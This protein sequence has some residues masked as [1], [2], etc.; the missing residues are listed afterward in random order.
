MKIKQGV[1]KAYDIR[2]TYPD[3]VNEELAFRIGQAFV[4]FLKKTNKNKR[5]SR[6]KIVV[7]Q[8]NRLSSPSLFKSLTKGIIE[9]GA[10]VIDIGLSPAPM[11]YFGVAFYGFDGGIIVTSSH[12]PAKYNGFKLVREKAIP[13]SEVTGLKVIKKLTQDKPVNVKKKGKIT[14]KNISKDYIR[15][16][17]EGFDFKKFKPFKIVIDTAN[18]VSGVIIPDIFKKTPFKIYSLFHELDGSFPNHE[19]DPMKEENL[20]SLRKEVSKTKS[21]LGVAFDGDGDRIVFITE[22][23]EIIT[24]DIISTLI[25]DIILKENKGGKVIYDVRS[26]NIFKE[27]IEKNG[28][29]ALPNRIGHSFI[30]ERMRK[31]NIFFAGEFSSHYYSKDHYFCE[32]PFWILFLILKSMSEKNKTFSQLVEPFKKYFHSG[33]INFTVKDKKKILKILEKKYGKNKKVLKV[34]GIKIDFGDWWFNLRLSNT[35]PLV[36]LVLEAKTKEILEKRKEELISF[37]KK[38][39][40]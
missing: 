14:K 33:E 12:N 3:G 9:S 26:S 21:D 30:K 36:R 4:K 19:P 31:E 28:G 35:E 20:R 32:C 7:G 15:F 10:D 39:D 23:G 1:F 25:A 37:I 13:I 5:K 24:G 18:S 27:T 29:I 22:K 38:S 34:D 11:F 17:L 2:A 40:N 6:L 8:D 16:N